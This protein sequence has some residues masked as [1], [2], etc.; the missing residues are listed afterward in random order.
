MKPSNAREPVNPNA[1]N[2]QPY[3]YA[4]HPTNAKQPVNGIFVSKHASRREGWAHLRKLSTRLTPANLSLG[5]LMRKADVVEAFWLAVEADIVLQLPAAAA[6]IA[7][8]QS[9]VA[10]R[11]SCRP[12][13]GVLHHAFPPVAPGFGND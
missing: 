11:R 1:L 4:V 7:D 12:T 10:D 3:G 2:T 6:Y 9:A 5:Q 13:M 8:M